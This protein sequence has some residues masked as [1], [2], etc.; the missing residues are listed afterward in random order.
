[1]VLPGPSGLLLNESD[2]TE[3]IRV[4]HQGH[5]VVIANVFESKR[6]VCQN[7]ACSIL[8]R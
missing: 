3:L 6:R 2:G 1:M 7:S 4:V 5:L 8:S